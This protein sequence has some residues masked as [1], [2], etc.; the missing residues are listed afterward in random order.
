[1]RVGVIGA[2]RI[3][4][5]HVENLLRLPEVTAVA[6][7]DPLPEAAAAA[8]ALDER[9]TA[10]ADAS[11]LTG[12]D[13]V[14]ICS[15]AATH[16]PMIEWAVEHGIPALCEKPLS[17][18]LDE[19]D[20]AVRVVATSDVPIQ[21]GFNRRFDAGYRAAHRAVSDGSVGIVTL[22]IGQHHDHELSSPEYIAGSG[23]EFKDQLIHDIDILRFV[24]G[25]DVQRLHAAGSTTG[26]EWFAD[27]DDYAHTAVTLWM[28]GGALAVLCGSRRDPVGYDVRM[29]IHGTGDSIAVGL[30]ER[31][32]LRSVE[33][34]G[35]S[36]TDPYRE[37]VPRFGK[38]YEAE[39]DAFISLALGRGPN[40]CTVGDGR[41]AL[42]IAEACALSAREGRI[43]DL[44]EVS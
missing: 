8:A 7:T 11:A 17:M 5:I 19:A 26:F 29:E 35:R 38:T 31:T 15:P 42:A 10:V 18:S 13:A 21:I 2:G 27:H 39:L 9:V 32:P 24:T 12:S 28:E 4:V 44:E 33:P 43:V 37:W 14:V 40:P 3:G 25:R 6:V 20:R 16:V 36:P 23:G 30:D 22:V 34:G 41:A 1:V